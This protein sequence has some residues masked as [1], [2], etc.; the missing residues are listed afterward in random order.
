M[1]VIKRDG[2]TVE[3]DRNKIIKAIR[4]ANEAV[5]EEHR[6]SDEQI[7]QIVRSIENKKRSRYLVED[8]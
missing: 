3:F 6:I 2:K 7:E 5:E 1:K 8:I 4:Q